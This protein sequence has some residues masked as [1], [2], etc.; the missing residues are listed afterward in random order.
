V[1]ITDTSSEFSVSA[2]VAEESEAG[3][4]HEH[5]IHQQLNDIWLTVQLQAVWRPMVR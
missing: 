3:E 5:S 2:E 1:T 4:T